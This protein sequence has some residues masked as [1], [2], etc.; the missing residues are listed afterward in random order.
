MHYMICPCTHTI[1]MSCILH[2]YVCHVYCT[3]VHVM[4]ACPPISNKINKKFFL[5]FIL[6]ILDYIDVCIPYMHIINLYICATCAHMYSMTSCT[7][8][9]T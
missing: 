6:L 5:Y 8:Y 3:L 7:M 4:Y 1:M 9:Q 2:I